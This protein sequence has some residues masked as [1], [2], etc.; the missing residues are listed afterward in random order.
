L[1]Q[2]TKEAVFLRQ[3]LSEFEDG[4]AGYV[5]IKEDNQAALS[6]AQNPVFHSK[7]KHTDVCYHF[8]CK[9]LADG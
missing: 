9:A 1:S 7:T 5:I 4:D 2:G 8:V 3:L 6:I